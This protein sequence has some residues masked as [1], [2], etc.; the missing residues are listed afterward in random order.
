MV[1]SGGC[2]NAYEA[3]VAEGNTPASTSSTQDSSQAGD[4]SNAVSSDESG[5][6]GG[7]KCLIETA[8]TAPAPYSLILVMIMIVLFQ[9]GRRKDLE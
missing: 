1:A 6:G 9:V 4:T 2:V 3:L 8:H 7:S 5:G